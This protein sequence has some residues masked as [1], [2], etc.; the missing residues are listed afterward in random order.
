VIPQIPVEADPEPVEAPA[1][2]PAQFEQTPFY[3]LEAPQ[4]D[5][6]KVVPMEEPKKLDLKAKILAKTRAKKS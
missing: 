6:P 1:S 4:E 2:Q 5:V 3:T